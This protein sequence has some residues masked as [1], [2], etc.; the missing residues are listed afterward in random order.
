MSADVFT[1]S[2]KFLDGKVIDP[3]NWNLVGISGAD[4]MRSSQRSCLIPRRSIPLTVRLS[5]A[6]LVQS[7]LQYTRR[8]N[9]KHVESSTRSVEFG[10]KLLEIAPRY[11]LNPCAEYK[12]PRAVLSGHGSSL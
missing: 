11:A 6:Y 5:L 4:A 1:I 2:A 9:G 10:M 12:V 3:R 7:V 8:R